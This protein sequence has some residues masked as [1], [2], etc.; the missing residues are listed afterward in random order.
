[1]DLALAKAIQKAYNAAIEYLEAVGKL[2]KTNHHH[3][4]TI[5]DVES[6]NV[7]YSQLKSAQWEL[8]TLLN[9]EG[10]QDSKS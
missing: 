10:K 1:M 6:A 9:G 7:A 5:M 3:E 8:N 4:V 2:G